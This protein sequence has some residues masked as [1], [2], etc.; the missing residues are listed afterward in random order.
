MIGGAER[1]DVKSAVIGE[2]PQVIIGPPDH[3]LAKQR[4]V[5]PR[6]IAKQR[7]LCGAYGLGRRQTN[8]TPRRLYCRRF[9]SSRVQIHRYPQSGTARILV[10]TGSTGRLWKPGCAAAL[11]ENGKLR[12]IRRCRLCR[13]TWYLLDL[14]RRVTPAKRALQPSH[15]NADHDPVL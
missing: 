12:G 15:S 2:H 1:I 5:S 14:V 13:R 10:I 4:S 9:G 8:D 6:E 3:P 7:I 11:D